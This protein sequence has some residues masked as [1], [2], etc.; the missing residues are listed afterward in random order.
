[1]N[2]SNKRKL[3]GIALL[4][5]VIA[6]CPLLLGAAPS[7]TRE[8]YVNDYGNVL[9]K[10]TEEYI[11][12]TGEALQSAT[13]AQV[14][15]LTVEDLGGEDIFDLGLEALRQWGIGDGEKNN[16]ALII[17]SVN[18][19]K[20]R[21]ITGYGLEGSLTDLKCG[22]LLDEYAVPHYSE[23]DFDTGTR[24]L[25]TAVVNV[26]MKEEY[27]LDELPAYSS[28]NNLEVDRE[29]GIKPILIVIIPVLLLIASE[30]HIARLRIYDRRHGT[31]RAYAFRQ[32]RSEILRTIFYL[33]LFSGRGGR[34]GG[35]HSGG[36][37]GNSGGGGSSGGGGAGRSF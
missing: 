13:T 23:N 5:S 8:F 6:L 26:V 15:V 20:V 34:G 36:G 16:G 37:R 2:K 3:K 9:S 17:L 25:Y 29:I 35:G 19:R 31:N 28:Q 4:L 10:E 30:I 33:V 21:I 27:G 11:V 18:D 24:E 12:K 7:P 1:M 22:K 14:C 32:A